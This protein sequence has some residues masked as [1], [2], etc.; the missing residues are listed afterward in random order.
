MAQNMDKI[1]VSG[2][3]ELWGRHDIAAYFSYVAQR[4]AHR[5]R[6]RAEGYP[7][8]APFQGRKPPFED[9]DRRVVDPAVMETCHLQVKNR[10]SM[11]G[12]G[13]VMGNGLVYRDSDRSCAIGLIGP[14]KRNSLVVH[15]SYCNLTRSLAPSEEA[16]QCW[17]EPL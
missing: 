12:T 9:V 3:I 10:P 15:R 8:R 5:R 2:T 16:P 14:M 4:I 1:G 7:C 11:S 17:H 13:E 6:T